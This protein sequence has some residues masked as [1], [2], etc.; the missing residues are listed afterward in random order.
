[1]K[2]SDKMTEHQKEMRKIS[3]DALKAFTTGSLVIYLGAIAYCFYTNNT[4]A[5]TLMLCALAAVGILAAVTY[6]SL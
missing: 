4:L 2:N 5:A 6:K 3:R 1:M